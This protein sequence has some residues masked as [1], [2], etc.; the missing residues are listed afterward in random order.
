MVIE[1]FH[2]E[3]SLQWLHTNILAQFWNCELHQV[4]RRVRRH[5]C[6]WG[7]STLRFDI[8]PVEGGNLGTA[9][10]YPPA[11]GT[12]GRNDLL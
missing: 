1:L 7:P 11:S 3:Y 6:L 9:V 2:T 12:I 10:H 8:L 4:E 5:D